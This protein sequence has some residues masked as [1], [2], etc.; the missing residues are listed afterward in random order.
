MVPFF[1]RIDYTVHYEDDNVYQKLGVVKMKKVINAGD[2]Q[3][4]TIY[5]DSGFTDFVSGE[6][7]DVF[8]GIKCEMNGEAILMAYLD[9]DKGQKEFETHVQVNG[10]TETF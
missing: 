7:I 1:L 9:Y 3:F 8:A 2:L 5:S 6:P 10:Q 4:K